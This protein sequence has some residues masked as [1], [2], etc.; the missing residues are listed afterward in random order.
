VVRIRSR[1]VTTA[2]PSS[3]S[4]ARFRDN[5][6]LY[7]SYVYAQAKGNYEGLFVSGYEQLDPNITA[8]YDLPSFLNNAQG[9]LRADKP[10]QIKVHSSYMFPFGLTVSEGLL[11]L[12]GYSYLGAWSGHR[13]TATATARS[14]SSRAAPRVVPRTTTTSTSTATTRFRCSATR[15]PSLSAV[16][17]I[18]NVTKRAQAARSDHRLHLPG[19]RNSGRFPVRW[20]V[21]SVEPRRQR[22]GPKF[23]A[24]LPASKFFGKGSVCSR[25][26]RTVQVGL[27]LTY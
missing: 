18:F 1:S 14:S 11:L 9:K 21:R 22:R 19:H 2:P 4:S 10:A 15:P 6:Q 24:A 23:N 7:A 3:P 12:V 8:L 25:P 26:P 20:L 5:W 27:R 13:E 16:V 17:D